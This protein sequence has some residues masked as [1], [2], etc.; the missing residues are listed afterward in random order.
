MNLQFISL[1]YDFNRDL[2]KVEQTGNRVLGAKELEYAKICIHEEATELIQS[3][4]ISD[5]ADC[6]VSQVDALVDAL[7]FSVGHL[8]RMGHS[9]ELAQDLISIQL[10]HMRNLSSNGSI[11]EPLTMGMV[12]SLYQRYDHNVRRMTGLT[13]EIDRSMAIDSIVASIEGLLAIGLTFGQAAHVIEIVDTKNKQKKRGVNAR[14]DVGVEDAVKP[15]D[16]IPPEVEIKAFLFGA[17]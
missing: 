8:Y 2:L 12:N 5:V 17:R 4:E 15:V 7:Y 16:W 6:V 13:L 11:I 14:R 3:F 9:I 1:I 10:V